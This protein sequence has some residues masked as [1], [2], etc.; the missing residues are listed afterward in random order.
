[1]LS[2]LLAAGDIMAA[3]LLCLPLL[4]LHEAGILIIRLFTRKSENDAALSND[5]DDND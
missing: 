1:M 2:I 5:P 3:I 4:A